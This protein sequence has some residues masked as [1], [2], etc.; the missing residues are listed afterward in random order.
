MDVFYNSTFN[1]FSPLS[2]YAKNIVDIKTGEKIFEGLGFLYKDFDC[3]KDKTVSIGEIT[4]NIFFECYDQL[5]EETK[6]KMTDVALKYFL[7][8]QSIGYLTNE[9]YI[10]PLQTFKDKFALGSSVSHPDFAKNYE[11]FMNEE[12]LNAFYEGTLITKDT[13]NEYYDGNALMYYVNGD[14]ISD[15]E[16]FETIGKNNK[17]GYIGQGIVDVLKS[18]GWTEKNEIKNNNIYYVDKEIDFPE[19]KTNSVIMRKQYELLELE[20]TETEEPTEQLIE[21]P[22]VEQPPQ[23]QPPIEKAI[24]QTNILP[25]NATEDKDDE[26]TVNLDDDDIDEMKDHVSDSENDSENENN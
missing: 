3:I 6:K 20:E 13:I 4:P 23:I 19:D 26:N 18:I 7:K 9:G 22:P 2:I 16:F 8:H 14:T 5:N 24:K 12:L 1:S 21:Q 17:H 11:I 25:D 10:V 15:E